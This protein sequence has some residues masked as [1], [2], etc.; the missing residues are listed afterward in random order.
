VAGQKWDYNAGL[1]GY[2]IMVSPRFRIALIAF[3]AAWLNVVLPGHTRGIITVPG[4][5]P[6]AAASCHEQTARSVGCCG[7]PQRPDG[8]GDDDRRER[9]RH[10][11]VCHFAA[12]LTPPPVIDATLAPLA[13]LPLTADLPPQHVHVPPC[14]LPFDG[15]GPP[16]A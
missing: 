15:R 1:R 4:Y 2:R 3:Q 9:E 7:A 8:S 5:R 6:A 11:A 14:L 10:C 16:V 13:R 12:K